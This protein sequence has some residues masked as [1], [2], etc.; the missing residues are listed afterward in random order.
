MLLVTVGMNIGVMMLKRFF[1]DKL[2][3][4]YFNIYN[5]K[6]PFIVIDCY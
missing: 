2:T 1:N 3:V 4:T 5:L 6:L